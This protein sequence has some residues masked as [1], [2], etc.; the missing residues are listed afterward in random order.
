MKML[1]NFLNFLPFIIRLSGRASAKKNRNFDSIVEGKLSLIVCSFGWKMFFLF[2]LR[3]FLFP[4]P[5]P[6][7]RFE[8]DDDVVVG[9]RFALVR[10]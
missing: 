3:S 1:H 2:S 8:I 4:L 9:K 6:L 5:L 10:M 7:A